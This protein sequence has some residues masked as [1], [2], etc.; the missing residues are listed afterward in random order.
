MKK[1]KSCGCIIFKDKEVLLVKHQ[2]GH[3]SF[4]KGHQEGNETDKETAIRE[5]K[6]ETNI[7]VEILSDKVFIN[8]YSPKPNVIKDVLFYIAKPVSFDT[9]NQE[10][11]VEEVIYSDYDTALEL[12]THDDDK[13]ILKEAIKY[14]SEMIE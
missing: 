14:Y 10:K 7:D 6:E 9:I 5:V 13:K 2:A 11:E 8:T 3:Y 12:I 1:E 4:P